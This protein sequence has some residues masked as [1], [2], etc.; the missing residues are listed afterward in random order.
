ME[1][2][3]ARPGPGAEAARGHDAHAGPRLRA[4][5]RLLRHRGAARRAPTTSRRSP[6]ASPASRGAGVQRRHRASCA[7]RSTSAA[8]SAP[9]V[10]NASCGLCGKATLD[11]V[12]QHVR[13]GRRRA[14]SSP[15]S[16]LARCP[17]ACAPRRRVFDATG[18]LHAAACSRPT[19]SCSSLREDVGRHNARRQADRP[20]ADRAARCPLADAVLFVSGRVSFEIVQ[21]AAVAGHPDRRRGVGAVEPRGR[22]RARASGRPSSGF[23]RDD[24]RQ[25]VHAPRAHRLEGCGSADGLEGIGADQGAQAH[26]ARASGWA[27]SP[28]GWARRS[29]TTTRTWPRPSGRTATTCPYAWRILQQG[30]VRRLRARRRR[31]ST[32]GRITGVH[33]CTTRLNL[34]RINTMGALDPAVLGDVARAAQLSRPGAA[35]PRPPRRTRWCAG[36]GEP[37]FTR[38]SWDEA[39][40]LV[41]DAHP[42]QP[43]PTAF[44]R[45]PHRARHHQ[46]DLLR[47]A[48]GRPLPRH[49]QH[50]QRG[51]H[52]PRAVDGRAQADDRRR[53]HDV[54]L[55]RRD[56]Q[57]PHRAVRRERRQRAAGV[58]E[59]PVPRPQA[60][61]RRSRWSTRSA[62]P[63]SSATGCRATSRARCSARRWPTSSSR[64]TPAATSRSST[65][66]SR[67]CSPRA[68]IDRAFVATTPTGFDELLAELAARVVRRP[69]AAVGRDSRRH[70]ALRPHVRGGD[71]R[72]SSS[73]RW[74][75]PSTRTAPTTCRDRQPRAGARQRRPAAARA[76]CRSAATPACRAAPRW[77]PTPPR[78]R[79]GSRSTP[80]NAA[81]LAE[82]YGFPVRRRARADR[83]GDARA[84]AAGR[85]RRP[86]L[87]GRQ[88]P[89]GAARRPTSSSTRSAGVPLRVHQDIV[90]SSQMLVDPADVVVLL[91]AATRY[92]QRGGGTETT[93]ERRIAFSP[94]IRGPRRARRAASGRSSSTS[95]AASIPSAPHLMRLRVRRRRSAT[96][97]RASC[98]STRGSRRCAP[99]ATRCSGAAGGS[100][101]A[102]TSRPPDG[103]ARFVPVVAAV[104]RDVPDGMFRA[105]HA[106]R[107]QFNSMVH[108]ENDPLTGAARDAVFMAEADVDRARPQRGRRGGGALRARRAPGHGCM[109]SRDPARATCRCSSPRATC[110]SRRGVRDPESRHPRLQRRRRAS[111][112]RLTHGGGA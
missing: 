23:L 20:R 102:A 5:G 77:A 40:D 18:G 44:A 101:R 63:G 27:S 74:G 9:F 82:Q 75:S 30:R 21:K 57:R 64:S 58:H 109:S 100:A 29:P 54:L 59:V 17:D 48:E 111:Q 88:L 84:G 52:V 99:P 95:R 68:A 39:L 67:C 110:C 22:R 46:R 13:A 3:R 45:L 79:A 31:A 60:R 25:R 103:R 7:A 26:A 36:A 85:A 10:A 66:C 97:S 35:R 80:A 15:R 4:R 38:V 19:A 93:T 106:A 87:V 11:Q 41:A 107:K 14:R 53:R 32:T 42:A 56:R 73:G 89:R 65:A 50:R 91:P 28:T 55:H 96:R 70:G 98:P 47:R 69:G 71:A 8:T 92:E 72:R 1:I 104:D 34:L 37:G 83:R 49:Q 94:E 16:V 78:S 86:L 81:A 105:E 12:E 33:L 51:P 61:A 62:S 76:S 90:L 6:T 2:R 24:T 108:A 43:T 112:P